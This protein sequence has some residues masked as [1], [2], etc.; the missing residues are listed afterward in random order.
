MPKDKRSFFE[1]L[2][3][4]V[5]IEHEDDEME[6]EEVPTHRGGHGGNTSATSDYPER[7]DAQ[8]SE[9][10]EESA[11]EGQLTVDVFQTQNDIVIKTIVAGVRPEDLDISISR[12]MVTIKGKREE[13]REVSED[14]YFHRELYWGAF[15]RTFFFQKKSIPKWQKPLST[16]VFSPSNFQKSTRSAK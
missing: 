10:I 5:K 6:Y 14:D 9:W 11:E 2:T 1:R 15:S 7:R 13:S 12:D 16:T 3:G 4:A 8:Q